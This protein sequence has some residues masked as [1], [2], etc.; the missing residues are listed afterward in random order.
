MYHQTTLNEERKARLA[1]I[2]RQRLAYNDYQSALEGIE[3]SIEA[4]W[5]KRVKKH[6]VLPKKATGSGAPPQ[7]PPV[8]ENLKRLVVVR[9]EWLDTVG[10]L[11]QERS[12]G[13]VV[14]MP[15]ESIFEGI[16]EETDDNDEMFVEEAMQMETMDVDDAE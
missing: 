10:R 13:E 12:K 7:R 4:S 16:G 8:P 3:K 11:M 9:K 1:S 14:G 15:T 6:G 5:S 2:A